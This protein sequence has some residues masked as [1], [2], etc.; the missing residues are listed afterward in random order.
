MAQEVSQW[1]RLQ[2]NLRNDSELG[3]HQRIDFQLVE[4]Y[5]PYLKSLALMLKRR[6]TELLPGKPLSFTQEFSID[7]A[8][9]FP[10]PKFSA[11]ATITPTEVTDSGYIV[12][13]PDG[14]VQGM[15]WL[16]DLPAN[17]WVSWRDQKIINEDLR[18]V[19]EANPYALA[20]E[21]T[22]VA[23]SPNRPLH[24]RLQGQSAIKVKS[25]LYFEQ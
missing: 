21:I 2:E 8:A 6:T 25:V 15:G 5:A 18:S 12:I 24:V 17:T 4:E 1:N 22:D 19:L 13:L 14:V 9:K 10:A 16:S 23:I 11:L 7:Q 3:I 20:L